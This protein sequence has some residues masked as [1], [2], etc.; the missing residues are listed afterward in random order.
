MCERLP[1]TFMVAD[2]HLCAAWACVIVI[3]SVSLMIWDHGALQ[4]E[5]IAIQTT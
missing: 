5:Q 1:V 4:I 3:S 2:F